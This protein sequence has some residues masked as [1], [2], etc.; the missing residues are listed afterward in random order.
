MI[1]F[2]LQCEPLGHRFEGWFGSSADY[3]DQRARGLVTCPSC[4][5]GQ[6]IKAVMAPNV[7]R[8]GNQMP[9]PVPKPEAAPVAMANPP[10]PAEA[11]AMLKAVAAMQAEAIKSSTWVGKNFAEDA[12]AMHYGEKDAAPIHGKATAQE[13]RELLD[14][15]VAVMPLLVPVVPPEEAN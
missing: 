14:E 3:E 15:G 8:K 4:G 7:G 13:A 6:V 2:D 1:V 11:V 10:L 12:R 9:A 5:A